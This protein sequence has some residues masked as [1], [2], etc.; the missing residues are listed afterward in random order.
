MTDRTMTLVAF[1]SASTVQASMGGWTHPATDARIFDPDYYIGVARTLERGGFDAMFIDDRLAMPTT[2]GNSPA[3]AVR[4][5][6]RVIKLDPLVIMS[7]LAG[8]TKTL[9]LGA[10]YSTTYYAPY[11][12]ARAFAT[13]DFMSQGRAVWNIVTSLNSDEA[14][15]FGTDYMDPS[16]R[17]DRADEF[18]EIV[19]QL[20]ESWGPGAVQLDRETRTFADPAKVR[21]LDYHGKFLS[22]KGPLTVPRPPQDWPLLLQA[23]QSGRGQQFAARWADLVFTA[24][25]DADGARTHYANH[26]RSLEEHGRPEG[27]ARLLPAILPIVG[28][29]EELALLKQ[30]IY[31]DN[32]D[33]GEQLVMLSE[34]ANVDLS[35]YPHDEPILDQIL[36]DVT[37]SQGL[38]ANAVARAKRNF[39]ENA[40][41]HDLAKSQSRGGTYRMVGSPTQVA[42]QLEE[43][44]TSRACDGFVL[45]PTFMPGAFED[46]SRLV[47]PEL[48]KRG[49]VRP[50]S[51]EPGPLR[52][53]LG[54]P[55]RSD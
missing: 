43:W 38:F 8:H 53:R 7:L 40:T 27:A 3:E 37:G 32:T 44:F 50:E 1:V 39:G 18:L 45:L 48:R 29:T 52:Q 26:Q 28:E 22:S 15:N 33:P 9:G 30:K 21:Q 19:T 55:K 24:P 41:V 47:V 13:L 54:F 12:V 17:Y 34:S 36:A 16:A 6:S 5:G 49:L 4:R 11:H 25:V 42:D 10:T 20:W 51:Y 14:E 35:K 31:D 46:F 23:G 2:Y